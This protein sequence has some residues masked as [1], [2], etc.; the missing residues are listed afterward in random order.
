MVAPEIIESFLD[1]ENLQENE[2]MALATLAEEERYGSGESTSST[3]G[4]QQRSCTSCSKA[5]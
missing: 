3:K 2:I 1:F 4:I 5:G